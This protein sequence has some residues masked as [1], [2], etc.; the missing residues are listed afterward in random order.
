[1]TRDEK[2][3]RAIAAALQTATHVDQENTVEVWAAHVRRE[4]E[5]H[6]RKDSLYRKA[7][8]KLNKLR[9]AALALVSEC[10]GLYIS[11]VT[12]RMTGKGVSAQA[13]RD[14][15]VARKKLAAVLKETE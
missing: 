5:A 10:D 4:H 7:L 14:V 13:I 6:D 3:A 2:W 1:M 8:A 11:D 12:G 15:E 9:E